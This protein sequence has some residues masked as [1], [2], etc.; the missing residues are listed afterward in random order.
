MTGVATVATD[1][2][3]C[4]FTISAIGYGPTSAIALSNVNRFISQVSNI[5]S[6]KGLSK[7]NYTTSGITVNPQYNYT[8]DGLQV[9]IG[10]QAT[11][12]LFVTVGSI[13]QNKALIGQIITAVSI[14]KNITI[15]GLSFSNSDT[16]LAYRQARKAAVAD[17][18]A[19]AKQYASL[20][21]KSLGSVKSIVD[22]NNENY[23][24]YS[25]D[26][27]LYALKISSLQVPYSQVQTSAYVTINWNLSK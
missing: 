6:G 25:T 2:D 24:P 15:S 22:Q 19:K 1:P 26:P 9:L 14:V 27:N 4:T 18:V 20:S 8:A 3:I 17:A 13:S 5:L 12:S 7:S 21:G 16:T 23:V 11:S 10:E